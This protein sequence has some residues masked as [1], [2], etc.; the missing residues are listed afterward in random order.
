MHPREIVSTKHFFFFFF[1]NNKI[2]SSNE[3]IE[4]WKLKPKNN[5]KKW[6]D[7]VLIV[8]HDA[9][10]KTQLITLKTIDMLISY[11]MTTSFCF[12][13]KYEYRSLFSNLN[14]QTKSLSTNSF[15]LNVKP[16]YNLCNFF[17]H[18]IC[19]SK[20]INVGSSYRTVSPSI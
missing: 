13:C 20:F 15:T 6:W 14:N 3:Q 12:E 2:K 16:P 10:L 4:K 1:F 11:N 8:P 17:S 19:T 18:F 7:N 9:S 5:L